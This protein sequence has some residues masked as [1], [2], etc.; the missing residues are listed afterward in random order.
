MLPSFAGGNNNRSVA[1]A[2]IHQMSQNITPYQKVHGFSRVS[3]KLL[4]VGLGHPYSDQRNQLNFF[5]THY[6][7]IIKNYSGVLF[8]IKWKSDIYKTRQYKF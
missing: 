6:L 4:S 1:Q 7:D 8:L 5:I 3:F 2:L